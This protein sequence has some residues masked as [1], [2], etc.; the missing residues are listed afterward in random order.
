MVR[1]AIE[2]RSGNAERVYATGDSSGG[3]MTELLLAL[4]PDVFKAG[5]AMAGMPAGCRGASESGTA[6]GY[7]GACAGGSV[8]HTPAE[9]G[10][11]ARMMHQGYT[12][13]RPRVQLFHGDADTIIRS[14]N[15]TEAIKQWT[16]VL[17]LPA[18]P[19]ATTMLTL[20]NHQATRQSFQNACGQ[21]CS[22]A[23]RR[24]GATTAR[25]TRCFSAAIGAARQMHSDL[26]DRRDSSG[27]LPNWKAV[28]SLCCP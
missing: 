8:T 18:N 13:H 12:G 25:P 22:T 5:S 2:T 9:W 11:I 10:D 6:G 26:I 28:P 4:Y 24:S 17:G 15:H 20:G 27:P 16:D 14:A 23:S 19:T 3:M 1:Y 21:V 7:S